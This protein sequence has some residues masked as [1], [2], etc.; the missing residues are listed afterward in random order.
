M[1]LITVKTSLR[2]FKCPK[3][4]VKSTGEQ[5]QSKIIFSNKQ[6]KLLKVLGTQ[7]YTHTH[8][9]IHTHTHTHTHTQI[10]TH[11]IK[12]IHCSNATNPNDN[13]NMGIWLDRKNIE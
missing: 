5:W 8:T 1:Y 10:Y 13:V 2:P 12:V 3:I 7:T 4:P 9:H 6:F 11:R